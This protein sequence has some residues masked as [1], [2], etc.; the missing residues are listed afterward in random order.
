MK[1]IN[2]IDSNELMSLYGCKIYE[3]K[4]TLR[5]FYN[6]QKLK[7]YTYLINNNLYLDNT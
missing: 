6:F 1:L 3:I 7:L 4:W 5:W 2:E